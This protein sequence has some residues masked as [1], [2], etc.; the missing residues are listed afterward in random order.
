MPSMKSRSASISRGTYCSARR[1][2]FGDSRALGGGRLERLLN[3]SS[4]LLLL[5]LATACGHT[6]TSPSLVGQWGGEHV[7]LTV[8]DQT[9]H[10]ELDCAH[11]D[12]RAAVGSTSFSSV[13]TVVL[14]HGGPSVGDTHPAVYAVSVSGDTMTLTIRL[15][16]SGELLGPFA[17][18][19]GGTGR[20][21]KCL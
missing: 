17:L 13:G 12:F 14:E 6:P 1:W 16:D 10:V 5:A 8:G 3:F 9:S 7:T 19:R 11:G 20:V 18:T 21:V 4:M 2:I 15:M